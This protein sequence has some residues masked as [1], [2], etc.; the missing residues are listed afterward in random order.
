[1]E[2][3]NQTTTVT[4]IDSA[5]QHDVAADS[6][7]ADRRHLDRLDILHN[8]QEQAACL[9][10]RLGGLSGV[11]LEGLDQLCRACGS[12]VRREALYTEEINSIMS[13][14]ADEQSRHEKTRSD[15]EHCQA[16]LK[17]TDA[18]YRYLCIA[19]VAEEGVQH[20]FSTLPDQVLW[21]HQFEK[22][23][24]EL[25]AEGQNLDLRR[26]RL[27]QRARH[28]ILSIRK[29]EEFARKLR[30][31]MDRYSEW[32]DSR[33]QLLQRN[34]ERYCE[35]MAENCQP[36]LLLYQGGEELAHLKDAFSAATAER[37]EAARRGKET[38]YF[39]GRPDML[40]DMFDILS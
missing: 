40:E 15:L 35:I 19:G 20:S 12:R 13:M 21:T 17:A 25:H 24:E 26:S 36:P 7:A 30:A 8:L 27:R 37:E 6:R 14:W 38:S 2:P 22:T 34:Y 10:T 18:A 32:L 39:D 33:A 5:P 3:M 9:A 29:Y 1:M 11:L 23:S 4:E 16:L 28:F 31:E